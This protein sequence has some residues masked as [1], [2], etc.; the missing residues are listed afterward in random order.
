MAAELKTD[1]VRRIHLSKITPNPRNPRQN[2]S[3]ERISEL[4]ESIDS[5]GLL[6]PV[7]VRPV[8]SGFELVHGERRY[9]A[10]K[11]LGKDRIKAEIR[12]LDG[13]EALEIAITE[14]LQREDVSSIAEARSYQQLIDEFGITQTEAAERLGK[15]QSH[16]SNRLALL[17]LP[18]RLQN[19]ILHKR[20][21][22]WQAKELARAWGDY[23]LRDLAMEWDLSV[24]EI[25]RIVNELDDDTDA[26]SIER[27]LSSDLLNE[28]WG[29][30]ADDTDGTTQIIGGDGDIDKIESVQFI[31]GDGQPVENIHAGESTHALIWAT[32]NI[33][34]V[35][36]DTDLY[37]DSEPEP[38]RIHWPM[39]KILMGYRRLQMAA[40]CEYDGNFQTEIIFPPQYFAWE[41]RTLDGKTQVGVTE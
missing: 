15:S 6:Q 12:N 8:D 7:L 21:S 26:V 25:R 30:A 19:D 22:P 35:A 31:D 28:F 17:D 2:F 3:D 11:K 5:K 24:K 40:E 41:I 32:E 14:N 39:Q 13:S 38:I 23:Y 27:S 34:G 10:V 29:I 37:Q 36:I 1:E 9:R 33:D 16:I 20:F 18:E 4:S